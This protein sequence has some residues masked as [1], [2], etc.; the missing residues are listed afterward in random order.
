VD[1]YPET[2]D[3]WR[4]LREVVLT[5]AYRQTRARARAEDLTQEAFARWMT[6]R[7]WNPETEPSLARH[8]MKV[9]KSLISNEHTSKRGDYELR[10]GV[11]QSLVGGS[12]VPSAEAMS[13]ERSEAESQRRAAAARLQALREMLTGLDLE[14]RLIDLTAEG[15]DDRGE[16]AKATGRTRDQVY[17]GWRRIYR[18]MARVPEARGDDEEV[19]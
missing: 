8:L 9:V 18:Y 14:L 3:E 19:A 17:E 2:Q 4:Q 11:E 6:T 15:V 7:P 12:A 5:Y 13:L 1:R 10:A 16:Q